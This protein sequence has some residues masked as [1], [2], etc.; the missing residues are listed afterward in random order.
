LQG[1]FLRFAGASSDVAAGRILVG[2]K[3]PRCQNSDSFRVVRAVGSTIDP[4]VGVAGQRPRVRGR[5]FEAL[6]G[7]CVGRA[8][9]PDT[10]G[11]AQDCALAGWPRPKVSEPGALMKATRQSVWL[12]QPQQGL[13]KLGDS[14]P[15]STAT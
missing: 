7:R 15:R 14:P 1:P 9:A 11:K 3:R 6:S 2:L 13:R 12:V 10:P 8:S 5:G 4:T